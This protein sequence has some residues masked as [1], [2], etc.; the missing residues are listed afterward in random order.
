MKKPL[1]IILLFIIIVLLYGLTYVS[2]RPNIIILDNNNALSGLYGNIF[3]SE[4]SK[5]IDKQLSRSIFNHNKLTINTISITKEISD[6]FSQFNNVEVSVPIIGTKLN[7]YVSDSDPSVEVIYNNVKYIVNNNGVTIFRDYNYKSINQLQLPII[8]QASL[9]PVVGQNILSSE[10]VSFINNVFEQL[11]LKNIT[12]KY[13]T[14]TNSGTELN[15]YINNEPYYVKF[16]L[17][18]NNP[19][20]QAGDYLAAINYLNHQKITPKQ[21]I[22]VRVEGRVFYK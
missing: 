15:A 5:F 16:D 6:H 13:F 17:E 7:I 22:D 21:Y 8:N 18:Q 9:S 3:G 2:A 14:I 20:L 10:Q 1:A 4:L 11:K 12:V 19:Q